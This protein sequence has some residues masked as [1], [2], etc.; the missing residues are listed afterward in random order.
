MKEECMPE[1]PWFVFPSTQSKGEHD[2][3]GVENTSTGLKNNGPTFCSQ[4]SQDSVYKLI[5]VVYSSGENVGHEITHQTSS[6]GK[7]LVVVV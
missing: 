4:M 7:V 1:D 2:C 5:P 3:L 6:K